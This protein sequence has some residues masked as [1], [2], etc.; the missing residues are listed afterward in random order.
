MTLALTILCATLAASPRVV[1]LKGSVEGVGAATTEAAFKDIELRLKTAGLEGV[2]STANCGSTESCWTEEARKAEARAVLSVSLF[3]GPRSVTVD[4][5]A[6]SDGGAQLEVLTTNLAPGDKRLAEESAAF[7]SSLKSRME[8]ADRPV[9]TK[10][11]PRDPGD[12]PIQL[13]TSTRSSPSAPLLLAGAGLIAVSVGLLIAGLVTSSQLR[14]R[15]SAGGMLMGTRA[16]AESTASLA[17]GL[18]TGSL[19]S[20]LLGVGLAGAGG[21]V[22]LVE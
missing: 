1:I 19:I 3:R 18:A 22:W 8:A 12:Q 2:R 4:L 14:T 17:N 13:S 21:V 10:L 5:D 9:E 16:E 20:G 11:V 7:F 6:R 15:L